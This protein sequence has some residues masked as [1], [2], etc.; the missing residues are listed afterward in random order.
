MIIRNSIEK[1]EVRNDVDVDQTARLFMDARHGIG[2]TSSFKTT[3]AE[4]ISEIDQMYLFVFSLIK[5]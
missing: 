4:S 2:I 3:M 5:T 1:G